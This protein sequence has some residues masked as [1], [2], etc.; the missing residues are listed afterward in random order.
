MSNGKFTRRDLLRSSL[1]AGAGAGLM[2]GPQALM[3]LARAATGD[4]ALGI[5]DLHYVFCYFPGG[6]DIILGLDPKDPTVYKDE[7]ISTTLVQPAYNRLDLEVPAIREPIPGMQLGPHMGNLYNHADKM[8]IVRGMSMETL[9]HEV[10]RRRFLTGRAPA[11][12]NASSVICVCSLVLLSPCP[13]VSLVLACLPLKSSCQ[14]CHK[15][16]QPYSNAEAHALNLLFQ[17]SNLHQKKTN[18]KKSYQ[19]FQI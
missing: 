7:D 15:Q 11:G 3:Q 19:L 14:P 12:L 6:W 9:T 1:L 18:L 16:H 17:R 2:G 4:K 13:T 10:G 5:P 8:C